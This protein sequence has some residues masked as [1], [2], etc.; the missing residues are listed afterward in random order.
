MGSWLDV[1][2]RQNHC[3]LHNF[4]YNQ[5]FAEIFLFFKCTILKRSIKKTYCDFFFHILISKIISWQ[6]IFASELTLNF[7]K[8]KSLYCY[9]V[10]QIAMRKLC[11]TLGTLSLRYFFCFISVTRTTFKTRFL[12]C[13]LFLFF[14]QNLGQVYCLNKRWKV[15]IFAVFLASNK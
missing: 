9:H 4:L 7:R 13:Q 1:T 3:F 14:K 15:L 2:N 5:F 12:I 6:S 10:I 8:Q 11:K